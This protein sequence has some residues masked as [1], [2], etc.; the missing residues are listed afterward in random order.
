MIN[1]S[2]ASENNRGPILSRLRML[3]NEPGKVLEIGSGSG[4]HALHFAAELRHL[5]WQPTDQGGYFDGLV[6][7]LDA[8]PV[9]NILPPR[10]LDI[11]AAW[12]TS[13]YRYGFSANVLHIAPARLIAPFFAGFAGCIDG[14]GLLCVYG[15][16]KY[17]GA[18]TSES[19]A[20]FDAWLKNRNAES[21][22]RDIETLQ[23]LA[24][25]NGFILAQDIAMPANNQ[26][27]VFQRGE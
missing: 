2:R 22:V 4:Q 12:P 5:T 6:A 19:N 1:Y 14:G 15:P 20:R 21:G 11:A 3:F 10:Y 7:N 13:A 16:F 8:E 26:L 24:T 25:A 9:V 17:G 27:L 23:D 18:F